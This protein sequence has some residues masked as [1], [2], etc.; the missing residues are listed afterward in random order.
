MRPQPQA[1]IRV[2]VDLIEVPRVR[3][4][5]DRF[6]ER[7]LVRIFTHCELERYRGRLPELAARFAA[8]EAVAK[9][10]GVGVATLA[11]DGIGWQDVEVLPDG[12]GKPMLQLTGRAADLAAE[13]GLDV[14]DVSLSHTRRIAV[15][16]VA[17]TSGQ[18]SV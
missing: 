9:A 4:A 13:L 17:A 11:A 14:W 6:G 15:A 2:G 8:K 1:R 7:F 10:L 3:N 5:I 18:G 16:F 12:R